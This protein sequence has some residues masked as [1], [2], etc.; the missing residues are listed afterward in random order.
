M[1]TLDHDSS[2]EFLFENQIENLEDYELFFC[3]NY[4]GVKSIS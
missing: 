4:L 2:G 1:Q 3:F